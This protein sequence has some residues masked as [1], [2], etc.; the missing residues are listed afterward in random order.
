V[1]RLF[2]LFHDSCRLNEG[3]DDGHGA[4][5]AAYAAKLRGS[6]YNL[7]ETSFALL[8]EACVWHTD[9]DFS[10]HPTIG[11]CWDADRLDLGRVGMIP[12][13]KFMSTP[14]GK[15]IAGVGSIQPF[16]I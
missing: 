11:T 9:R 14:F 13:P 1:V 4:R 6:V 12:N 2:A 3:T 7:D 16:L 8:E 15:E 10:D 5:G